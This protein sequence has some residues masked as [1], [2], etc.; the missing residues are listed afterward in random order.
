MPT[1]KSIINLMIPIHECPTVSPE[2]TIKRAV[3]LLKKGT[4]QE[5]QYVLVM[6]TGK[7][8]TGLLSRRLLLST[9]EPEFVVTDRWALPV[10]W[11]GFFTEK[12]QEEAKKKVKNIMRPINLLTIEIDAP[13]I[14]AVH[15][16][17]SNH[18]GLLPVM[19][20]NKVLGILRIRE[21]FYELAG[22]ITESE[23]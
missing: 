11:N 1:D 13:I 16:M 17:V 22:H 14:K 20:E 4:E 7:Q 10:F 21:I 18:V 23:V 5:H 15:V 3:A 9:L 19:K 6:G 8:P 2:D 12:C